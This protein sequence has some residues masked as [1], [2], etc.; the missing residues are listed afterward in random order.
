MDSPTLEKLRSAVLSLTGEERADLAR[1]LIKSLDA[2]P[3]SDA[4]DAWDREIV[5]RLAEIDAGTASMVD[6]AELRR[7]IE[8]RINNG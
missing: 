4:A 5:R 2:P 7:R 8:Q 6:R 3:E 1:D